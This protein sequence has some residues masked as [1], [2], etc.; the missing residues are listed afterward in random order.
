MRKVPAPL[1]LRTPAPA[2]YF[3]TFLRD[4]YL[5][6]DLPCLKQQISLA[7]EGSVKLQIYKVVT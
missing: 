7:V 1:F 3:H 6:L 5:L 2:P 4:V